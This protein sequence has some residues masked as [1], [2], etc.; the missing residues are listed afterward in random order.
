MTTLYTH[1]EYEKLGYSG[2]RW[3]DFD[4]QGLTFSLTRGGTNNGGT[5]RVRAI[6]VD[7]KYDYTQL[8][9]MYVYEGSGLY[10]ALKD[11]D[12]KD[13]DNKEVQL[14]VAEGIFQVAMEISDIVPFVI[15]ILNSSHSSGVVAGKLSVQR[16]IRGALNL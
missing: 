4:H 2:V 6:S 15:R 13:Q 12:P 3:W 7:V 14:E 1:P 10:L 9:D 5:A 8:I 16:A 11:V